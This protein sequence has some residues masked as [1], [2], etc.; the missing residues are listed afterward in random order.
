M[1]SRSQDDQPLSYARVQ[2]PNAWCLIQVWLVHIIVAILIPMLLVAAILAGERVY[3]LLNE[4][5]SVSKMGT[6]IAHMGA[7]LAC[8]F[9][10]LVGFVIRPYGRRRR[11]HA[12]QC[13]HLR[14]QSFVLL[15]GVAQPLIWGMLPE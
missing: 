6:E 11:A 12:V 10:G 15:G 4:K 2:P 9:L 3:D 14:W 7:A 1:S 8:A 5:D 13:R